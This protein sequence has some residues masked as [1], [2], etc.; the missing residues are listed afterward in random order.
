MDLETRTSWVLLRAINDYT[1]IIVKFP[2]LV[3]TKN[4]YFQTT[5]FSQA[6]FL[7]SNETTLKVVIK[8]FWGK[9]CKDNE[10]QRQNLVFKIKLKK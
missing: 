6:C 10:D 8:R 2:S 1:V 9:R 4:S 5:Y 7:L 3:F